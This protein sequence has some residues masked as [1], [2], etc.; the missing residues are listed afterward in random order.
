MPSDATTV[1]DLFECTQCG[2]CCK[3]YG[4]TYVTDADIRNIAAF[5]NMP[6]E[7]VRRRYCTLSGGKPLLAQADNGYCVFWDRICTIHPVK[8]RMCRHWPFI[9]GVLID[10]LNWRTMADSCPGIHPDVDEATL[11]RWVAKMMQ[12]QK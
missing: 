8:P 6:A 12:E 7:T 1:G 5:L 3:G 4:G 11:R 2:E 9:A 10:P